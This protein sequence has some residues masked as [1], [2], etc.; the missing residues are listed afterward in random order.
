MESDFFDVRENL[1]DL[2]TH[3]PDEDQRRFQNYGHMRI[4]SAFVD[5]QFI[6]Y[7]PTGLTKGGQHNPPEIL[8]VVKVVDFSVDP[9]NGCQ[10][11]LKEQQTEQELVVSHVPRRLYAYPVYMCVPAKLEV[12]WD[13]R[14]LENWRVWRSLSFAVLVKT[15]NKS[16]FYSRGN[17]YLETPNSFGKLFPNA[18]SLQI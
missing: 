9:R 10:V 15:K 2:V 4:E 6:V 14:R 16:D 11:V 17:T 1:A 5:R 12:H 7:K 18:G 3:L 13:A 8:N